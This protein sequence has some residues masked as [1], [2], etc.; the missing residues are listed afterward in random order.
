LPFGTCLYGLDHLLGSLD[1]SSSSTASQFRY[2]ERAEVLRQVFWRKLVA[3]AP[4]LEARLKDVVVMRDVGVFLW[5]GYA[6]DEGRIDRVVNEVD[7]AE[8]LGR[9]S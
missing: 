2:H 9:G 3:E 7:D 5:L 8:E 1:C 6:W 4:G